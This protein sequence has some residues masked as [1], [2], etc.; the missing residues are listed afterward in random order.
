VFHQFQATQKPARSQTD[1]RSPC[2]PPTALDKSRHQHATDP[3]ILQINDGPAQCTWLPGNRICPESLRSRS[4]R[5]AGLTFHEHVLVM[6]P[7]PRRSRAF[8][9]ERGAPERGAP[10]DGAESRQLRRVF[11]RLGRVQRVDFMR[12]KTVTLESRCAH[13]TPTPRR[14]VQHRDR[15]PPVNVHVLTRRQSDTP[16]LEGSRHRQGEAPRPAPPIAHATLS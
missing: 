5:A 15:V 7:S 11:T 10:R 12:A 3:A 14:P 16:S 1:P 13:D 4:V 2:P 8:P 9:R 6:S